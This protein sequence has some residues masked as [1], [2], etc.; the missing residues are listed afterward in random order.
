MLGMN[1]PK[2]S[3]AT[4]CLPEGNVRWLRF[5]AGERSRS[6]SETVVPRL[7][8][9]QPR[10]GRITRNAAKESEAGRKPP[11]TAFQAA[12]RNAIRA[13][14]WSPNQSSTWGPASAPAERVSRR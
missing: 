11:W 6:R 9:G 3:I 10:S 8:S 4:H 13:R 2:F 7:W 14:F 12:L 5:R 1:K